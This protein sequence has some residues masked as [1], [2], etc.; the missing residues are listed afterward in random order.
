MGNQPKWI[1]V[2]KKKIFKFN[3]D[4]FFKNSAFESYF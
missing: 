4:F 1:I 3:F 2:T